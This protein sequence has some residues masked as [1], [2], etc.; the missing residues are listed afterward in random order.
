MTKNIWDFVNLVGIFIGSGIVAKIILVVLFRMKNLRTRDYIFD[1]TII[2]VIKNPLYYTF[3]LTG[4]YIGLRRLNFKVR[5]LRTIDGVAYVA[6]LIAFAYLVSKIVDACIL[7][8]RINISQ[9]DDT[10]FNEEFLPL[11]KWIANIA[12]YGISLTMILSHFGQNI[13]GI[14]TALGVG[15]LAVALASREIIENILAGFTI[16]IDRPFKI[17]ERIKL[18]SGEKGIVESIGLRST[19]LKIIEDE[20]AILIVSNRE[21][22]RSRIVNFGREKK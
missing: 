2:R 19:K 10:K 4:L 5:V 22:V 20:K 11:I 7:W 1:R 18:P 14:I 21:L 15:S 13:S 9:E 3:F 17:G 16:M 6:I 12:I 8:Y